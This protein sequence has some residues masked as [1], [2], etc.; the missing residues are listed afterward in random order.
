VI[1]RAALA[2][3]LL[4]TAC[5]RKPAPAYPGPPRP[6][7]APCDGLADDNGPVHSPNAIAAEEN[8]GGYFKF[9]SVRVQL[10]ADG[11]VTL[12]YDGRHAHDFDPPLQCAKS[13]ITPA[14][15]ARFEAALNDIHLCSL[16]PYKATETDVGDTAFEAHLGKEACEIHVPQ[17]TFEGQA[18]V[19]VDRLYAIFRSLRPQGFSWRYGP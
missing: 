8:F 10:F 2:L 17:Q 1:R 7:D 9:V 16:G 3:A 15:M 5:A 11:T 13:K 12:V 19:D 4:V 6:W 14:E 18:R